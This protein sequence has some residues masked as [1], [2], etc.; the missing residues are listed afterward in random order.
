MPHLYKFRQGWQSENL[1]RFLLSEFAFIAQP[2]TIADDV[3]NDFY[4]TLFKKEKYGKQD[5]LLPNNSFVIQIKSSSNNINLSSKC[6]FLDQLELPFFIGIVDRQKL[7]LKIYSGRGLHLLFRMKG[8]PNKL[9]IKCMSKI[10]DKKYY[11]T[12]NKDQKHYK[13]IFPFLAE[14]NANSIIEN[15]QN[16]FSLLSSE[17]SLIHK[18]I[19]SC[20]M[21]EYILSFDPQKDVRIFAGKDSVQQ[22]RRN[23]CYRIAEVF[24]NIEW[25][26]E[27]LPQKFSKP[28][29]SAYSNSWTKIRPF[30]DLSEQALV[31]DIYNRLNK[32]VNNKERSNQ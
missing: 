22:F 3:G 27:N 9:V 16:I 14:I 2:S 19:S 26:L 7:N 24:Y 28:E 21:G 8:I 10:K 17:C 6:N 30:C 25:L 20:R 15:T 13:L 5:C 32:A 29:F 1:A 18:N 31:D 23:F 11:E 12:I 4:C